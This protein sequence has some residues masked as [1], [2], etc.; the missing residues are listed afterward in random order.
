MSTQPNLI[1]GLGST[2]AWFALVVVLS[3]SSEEQSLL[4]DTE[5]SFQLFTLHISCEDNDT[6][7]LSY[8]LTLKSC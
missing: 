1:L 5:N 4:L 7:D 2:A 6:S 8:S 3:R